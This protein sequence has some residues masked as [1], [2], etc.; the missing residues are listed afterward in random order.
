MRIDIHTHCDTTDPKKI[1]QFIE[2]C[3]ENQTQACIFSVGPRSSHD[4]CSNEDVLSVAKQYQEIL[5]PFAFLDL[6][7]SVDEID[8]LAFQ[9]AG[10]KGFKCTSPYYSYDHDIYMPIY[11]K[12]QCLKMPIIFHTGR[13][14]T[15]LSDQKYRR[16][17]IRNMQPLTLDRIA[18]SFPDLKI[19]I[20]HLG[21]SLF[22]HEAADLIKL[23]SNMYADLA[24]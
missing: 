16:P 13:Y 19:I 22:R 3:Q 11:E 20:A 5:I 24:G 1:R 21:T 8:L 2:T 12:A 17:V 7:E 15:N 4:F 10:F 18:R 6:W 23:H 14:R 9:E